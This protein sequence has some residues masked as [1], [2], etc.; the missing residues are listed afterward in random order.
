MG[1]ADETLSDGNGS[2]NPNQDLMRRFL[3][4]SDGLLLKSLQDTNSVVELNAIVT[5]AERE[6]DSVSNALGEELR[7]RIKEIMQ[8]SNQVGEG[9]DIRTRMQEQG[10]RSPDFFNKDYGGHGRGVPIM[11]DNAA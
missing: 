6:S 10:K 7:T 5:S 8:S 3:D 1:E 4:M 11:K 9:W 2:E